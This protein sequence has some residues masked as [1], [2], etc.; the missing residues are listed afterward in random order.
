MSS[1]A[2]GHVD[3]TA[4]PNVDGAGVKFLVGVL[5]G[6]DVRGRSAKARDHVG[7]RLPGHAEALAVAEIGNLQGAA[8]GEQQILGLEVAVGNAH[9]VEVL[10]TPHHLLEEAVGLLD[11]QLAARQDE[12]VQVA[13]STE[14]H[15][16]AVVALGVLEQVEGVDDVGVAQGRR[17]A[18]LGRKALAVLLL[19]LVRPSAELLDCEQLLAAAANL[20]VR[21][22]DDAKG[23]SADD[24]L[25][26]AV[27]LHQGRGGVGPALLVDELFF[28]LTKRVDPVGDERKVVLWRGFL[29]LSDDAPPHVGQLLL[30]SAGS[31]EVLMSA[32]GFGDGGEAT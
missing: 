31:Q 26:L 18:E 24:F 23:A 25:A 19:R 3:D 9:L 29:F 8:R 13:A 17:D 2:H 14:L 12:S 7:I 16:L 21:Y 4:G 1:G 11:L 32:L 5:L 27:L 6:S 22:P 10:D 28:F 20:F 15:D 30:S